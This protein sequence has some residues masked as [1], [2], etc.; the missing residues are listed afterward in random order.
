MD[1]LRDSG[2]ACARKTGLGIV[3]AVIGLG[4]VC[5]LGCCIGSFC[6]YFLSV[7]L[8]ASPRLLQAGMA[9]PSTEKPNT[10]K[11]P[12]PSSQRQNPFP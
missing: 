1:S 6:F 2:R 11:L 8:S 5:L 7:I 3:A 9:D 10:Q 4:F 12:W